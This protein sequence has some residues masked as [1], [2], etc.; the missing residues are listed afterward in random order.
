MEE[1]LKKPSLELEWKVSAAIQP[2]T[3]SQPDNGGT[4]EKAI[5]RARV[6]G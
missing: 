4:L 2:H 1:L 6:E 3:Q 5:L